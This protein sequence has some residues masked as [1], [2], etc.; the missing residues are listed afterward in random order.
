VVNAILEEPS[1]T[2]KL[3]ADNISERSHCRIVASQ[4]R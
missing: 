4:E 2:R 3:P 1:A